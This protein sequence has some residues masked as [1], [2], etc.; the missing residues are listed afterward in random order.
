[1]FHTIHTFH[2]LCKQLNP[3]NLI[4]KLCGIQCLAK[5]T[6]LGILFTKHDF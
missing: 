2:D 6:D 4:P 1:M 5:V 3:D